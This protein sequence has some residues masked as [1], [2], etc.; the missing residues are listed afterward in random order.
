MKKK[1]EKNKY[2][3]VQ[4]P[5][6]KITNPNIPKKNINDAVIDDTSFCFDDPNRRR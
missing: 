1:R 4:K 2:G 3:V 5:V 6:I